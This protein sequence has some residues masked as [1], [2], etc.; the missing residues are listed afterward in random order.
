MT[1]LEFDPSSVGEVAEFELSSAS[2]PLRRAA[3]RLREVLPPGWEVDVVDTPRRPG[4]V[5]AAMLRVQAPRD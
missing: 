5:A 1:D 4:Q 3:G 2:T